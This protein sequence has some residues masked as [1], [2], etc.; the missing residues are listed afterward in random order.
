[1]ETEFVGIGSIGKLREILEK[2][3][4]KKVFLVVD[5]AYEKS[6]AKEK[7][8][9]LLAR[10]EVKTFSDIVPN[11]NIEQVEKGIAAWDTFQPDLVV[12]VGGGSVL[13]TAKALNVLA[14]QS[15]APAFYVKKEAEITRSG[16]PLIAVPTT[17]GTG[18]EATHFAVVYIGKIKYSLSHSSVLPRYAIVDPQF[19][20]SLPPKITAD[21]GMDA[22]AQAV[23][24][25]WSVNST[26]ESKMYS[27]EAIKLA[28]K[29]LEEAVNNPTEEARVAMAKA[30]HLSGKAINIAQT[31]AC[32]ALSYPF[33]AHYG[34][35]HGHAAALTLPEMVLYNA[36]GMGQEALDEFLL[37]LGVTT[38]QEAADKVRSLM[39]EINL[40]TKLT[41]LGIADVE[42]IQELLVK[43]V[44][45]ERLHNNPRKLDADDIRSI[46]QKIF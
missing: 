4:P 30:A 15:K 40:G 7:I 6:G 33:T 19:T 17:A 20:F 25:Y 37:L 18:A 22:L 32:H 9:P 29:N 23:E 28:L 31:T 26:D 14:V 1:M 36:E 8:T 27:K 10:Y 44:N 41:E 38:P 5:D 13:D 11:P 2:E 34:I 45:T 21:T 42:H 3:K 43:E 16:K 12:A 35:P 46:I 39:K 24:A